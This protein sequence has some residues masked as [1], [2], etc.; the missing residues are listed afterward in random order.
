MGIRSLVVPSRT[1][2]YPKPYDAIAPVRRSTTAPRLTQKARDSVSRSGG[3]TYQKKPRAG[4][5]TPCEGLH[6]WRKN[7]GVKCL[8]PTRVYPT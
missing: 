6:D 5:T 4:A 3:A 8:T 2:E 1:H 7:Y